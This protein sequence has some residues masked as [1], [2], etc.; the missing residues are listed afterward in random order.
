MTRGISLLLSS[1][2]RKMSFLLP[3]IFFGSK[4]SAQLE[5][6]P[7][8]AR[9]HVHVE[10]LTIKDYKKAAKTLQI[11]F[12][13][14][15]YVNY[16]TSDIDDP[17]MKK[18]LDL[19]LFEGTT[20][21]A[22]LSG[23]CVAVRD[24]DAEQVDKDAPFLAVAC[25]DKPH[26][27]EDKNH[28]LF[29]YLW[30]MYEGGYLKFIWLANKETRQR[31]IEEQWNLLSDLKSEV[32]GPQKSRSWYLSD[33][34]AVPRGRGLGLSRRLLDYVCQNYIDVYK[35]PSA[36]AGDDD[37]DDD[38]DD[39]SGCNDRQRSFNGSDENSKLDSEIQSYN[40]GFNLDSDN[41][42]DYSGYSSFSDNEST[43]SSWYYQEENDILE[44]YDERRAGGRQLGAPLYL[45]SSHP[46]N[47]KIYQKL[48]F[49][50]VKTVTVADVVDKTGAKKSLTMDLMVRG[51]KGAKWHQDGSAPF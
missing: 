23:L 50:Y 21:N 48:G 49:T 36:H 33:I 34:G 9:E 17:K 14:D 26:G 29:S 6:L 44:Q 3:S 42:T 20:Y 47:R 18:Q 43:H 38:D 15:L 32:L 13:E 16:L 40:F 19:A 11:A 12:K 25:F 41:L 45:E 27:E 51:V 24:V 31:V 1:I 37:D 2:N 10:V 46:R 39:R 35:Q 8:V 7:P 4:K 22:I 30:G 28:S 5:D